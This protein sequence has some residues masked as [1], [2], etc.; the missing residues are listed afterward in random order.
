MHRAL[1]CSH[2]ERER[3]GM[4]GGTKQL[5]IMSPPGQRIPIIRLPLQKERLDLNNKI[6]TLSEKNSDSVFMH[7]AHNL[8]LETNTFH[9]KRVT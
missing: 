3:V 2:G 8:M 5:T 7:I 6:N 4:F 1:N 9:K